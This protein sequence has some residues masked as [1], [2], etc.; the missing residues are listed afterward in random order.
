MSTAVVVTLPAGLEPIAV[1]IENAAGFPAVEVTCV[2]VVLVVAVDAF[3]PIDE[4][5][6]LDADDTAWDTGWDT[7]GDPFDDEPPSVPW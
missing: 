6:W 7:A 2:G 3:A 1:R 5:E 4:S